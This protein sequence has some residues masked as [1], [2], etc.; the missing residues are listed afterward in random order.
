MVLIEINLFSLYMTFPCFLFRPATGIHISDALWDV[1]HTN[2]C[3]ICNILHYIY[4]LLSCFI[5]LFMINCY[6]LG[7]LLIYSLFSN[8]KDNVLPNA[9]KLYEFE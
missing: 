3:L 4:I 8:D 6:L 1:L 2:V 5:W 9:E 7:I